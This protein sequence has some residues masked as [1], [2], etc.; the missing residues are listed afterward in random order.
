[1][2]NTL[3]NR[4]SVQRSQITQPVKIYTTSSNIDIYSLLEDPELCSGIVAHVIE[5]LYYNEPNEQKKKDFIYRLTLDIRSHSAYQIDV[6]TAICSTWPEELLWHLLKILL[7]ADNTIYAQPVLHYLKHF[8]YQNEEKAYKKFTKMMND[9]KTTLIF[10]DNG[11]YKLQLVHRFTQMVIHYMK[12]HDKLDV[13]PPELPPAEDRLTRIKCLLPED[14]WVLRK[15]IQKTEHYCLGLS[16]LSKKNLRKFAQQ[17]NRVFSQQNAW[18]S[19]I[20][21]HAKVK[22]IHLPPCVSER[23][24]SCNEHWSLEKW[25]SLKY[26]LRGYCSQC[27]T[28]KNCIKKESYCSICLEQWVQHITQPV[29]LPCGHIFCLKCTN[30]WIPEYEYCP[31]CR[32]TIY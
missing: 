9:Y 14:D 7:I 2:G 10:Y 18:E 6:L 21:T 22:T 30:Q 4:P 20:D 32:T 23:C 26:Y 28:P 12:N 16:H 31:L 13:P 25:P 5:S 3:R 15:M 27:K 17:N 29:E 24:I 1:M 11:L 8:W 19:W